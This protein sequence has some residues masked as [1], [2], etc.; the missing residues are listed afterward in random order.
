M[1]ELLQI[2]CP[3]LLCLFLTDSPVSAQH[4][5]TEWEILNQEVHESFRVGDY[6]RAVVAATEA[7]TIAEV[8]VGPEQRYLASSLN[9]LAELYRAQGDYVSAKPLYL[10]SLAIMERV[11]GPNH[12]AVAINLNNLAT[13]YL[14][15]GDSA[16]AGSLFKRSL[17]AMEKALG[18]DHPATATNLN[19]LAELY[20]AQGDFAKAEPLHHRS[21]AIREKALGSEH[22]DF[23]TSL[24]NLAGLYGAQG[25]FVKS[26]AT[27]M[28]SLAIFEEALGPNHPS[29][30]NAL[31][32]LALLSWV[33]GDLPKAQA[34]MRRVAE[35]QENMIASLVPSLSESRASAF[36]AT[37]AFSTDAILSLQYANPRDP[38]TRNLAF[39]TILRRKGRVLDALSE[40]VA[41]LR[42]QVGP[43]DSALL[44]D[45]L[46]SRAKLARLALQGPAQGSLESHRTAAATMQREVDALEK[47]A[48][49]RGAALRVLTSSAAIRNVRA[50]LPADA[51]L[52]EIAEYR[53]FNPVPGKG[54]PP[55]GSRRY[56]AFVLRREGEVRWV[57]L[58]EAK[59]IKER[60]QQ[61]RYALLDRSLP[62]RQRP[63][64][65]ELYRRIIAPINQHLDD[66][67]H[68]YLA[69]DGALNLLP[70]GAL[71]DERNRY[72]IENLEITYV[73][74]GRDL[75]RFDL[76]RSPS[77]KPMLLAAPAFDIAISNESD[78]SNSV[79]PRGFRGM[80]FGELP[81]TEA[82]GRA[83]A[84]MLGVEAKMGSTATEDLVKSARSP[85][86]LHIAT[87]GFFL[88]DQTPAEPTQRGL[89]IA[90]PLGEAGAFPFETVGVQSR[91]NPLL[92]SGLAFAGANAQ[93]SGV[94]EDGVLTALEM[95]GLDLSG[96]ELVVLSACDTGVG[97][98]SVGEGVYGL[99]RALVIAGAE[100]QLVSL[101][102]VDDLAT[103][104]LMVGYY[105]RLTMGE[106]RG[107]A[108][109]KT[110][111][112]MINDDKFKHPYYWASFI[113]I[114][115]A[116]PMQL[117]ERPGSSNGANLE[118]MRARAEQ[119]NAK[120][121]HALGFMYQVG[122][123]VP[124]DYDQAVKW[125]RMAAEQGDILAQHALGSLYERGEGIQR[126]YGKAAMW[127]H[128]AAKQGY[129]VSQN[130]LGIMYA[131]GQGVHQDGAAAAA[132][133]RMAV[134][135]G[136]ADAMYNLG[137]LYA[138]GLGVQKDYVQAFA[139]ATVAATAKSEGAKQL[140]DRLEKRMTP[141]Q[142]ADAQQLAIEYSKRYEAKSD[143]IVVRE[144]L[145]EYKRN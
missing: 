30:A 9:N 36:M 137:G 59:E 122:E 92:R 134:E 104:D 33:L 26:E 54:K 120:D 108:L 77:S 70:F 44:D 121:Q 74:S 67:E 61:F 88:G 1:K 56:G 66:V 17:A 58:G 18:S 101:W 95:T 111:L 3:V 115:A 60:L 116:G 86:V 32:N 46:A 99:R 31:S 132:W 141:A 129:V 64:A 11:L 96:T 43:D 78:T 82:E 23:A 136:A 118:P 53:L 73:T 5:G 138:N 51:A 142:V 94:G 135:R 84:D 2:V 83:I 127:Y 75:L 16:K 69:P 22:P 35:N 145:R 103:K 34:R 14:A 40:N 109:R 20:L 79:R 25:D 55:W 100:S 6:D 8:N 4:A 19:N 27:H 114:G 39:T 76:S 81:G 12:H 49:R 102:K 126:D 131:T 97:A 37:L 140:V 29:V 93:E 47:A 85:R 50:A 71:I 7:L 68:V 57:D 10:R 112:A 128:K 110:Q 28:R 124:Q 125:Y 38:Q 87:H 117:G 98:I 15:Q 107:E 21:L 24:G 72:W 113:S 52:V 91:E 41:A 65:R 105:E 133:F 48:A 130:T 90:L 106:G 63:L 89:S 42:R 143:S 144:F 62:T 123:N 13:L 119:G 80:L 45:L 139:W